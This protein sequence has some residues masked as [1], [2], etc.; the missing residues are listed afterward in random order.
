MA[1]T[2]SIGLLSGRT[3]QVSVDSD[4][5]GAELQ[6]RAE[7]TLRT[8]LA[9][10]VTAAG[11]TLTGSETL[12]QAGI[13]DGDALSAVA[14]NAPD[15]VPSARFMSAFALIR[16]DGSVAAWGDRACGGDC[17]PVSDELFAVT[18]IQAAEWLWTRHAS[19]CHKRQTSSSVFAAL[20]RDGGVVSWG[21]PRTLC[22]QV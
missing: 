15:S 3:T 22:F 10:L 12:R 21:N 1:L 20:R 7:A 9:G 6:R 2:L 8:E 5:S 18:Q 11:K 14:G 17:S 16:G 4:V 19:S 13:R